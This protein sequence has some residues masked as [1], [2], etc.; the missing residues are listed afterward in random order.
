MQPIYNSWSLPLPNPSGI[1][2]GSNAT[3][4]VWLSP[5]FV[6]PSDKV[7]WTSLHHRVEF[8]ESRYGENVRV[9]ATSI[10]QDEL[11]VCVEDSIGDFQLPPFNLTVMPLTVVTAKVGVVVASNGQAVVTAP[12]ITQIFNVANGIL[13]Q[14]G[15]QLEMAQPIVSISDTNGYWDIDC[16]SNTFAQLLS[17]I[18]AFGGMKVYFVQSITTKAGLQGAGVNTPYGMVIAQDDVSRMGHTLAHETCHSC[19]LCDIYPDH[20]ETPLAARGPISQERMP[21]DWGNY[22]LIGEPEI[23]IE[24]HMRWLLMFWNGMDND[25]PSG[26]VYGVW[27]DRDAT[28]QKRWHLSNA[29]VGLSGMTRT[30]SHQDLGDH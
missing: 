6:V 10:G 16:Q 3:F 1:I 22:R 20:F 24:K 8:I 27:Y 19:G 11:R 12:S 7:A 21:N 28:G 23:Q 9:R 13:A 26:Q 14:T 2:L 29:P 18:E 30:P 5:P 4:S 17:E 25:I 15:M